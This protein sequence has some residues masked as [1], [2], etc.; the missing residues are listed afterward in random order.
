M[1]KHWSYE[2]KLPCQKEIT[3]LLDFPIHLKIRAITEEMGSYE[4]LGYLLGK[5]ES[6]VFYITDLYIPE[7]EVTPGSVTVKERINLENIIGTVHSHGAGKG[8]K[9][10]ID[11]EHLYAN[12]P[13]FLVTGRDGSYYCEARIKAPCGHWV[14]T[15]AK[16][17]ISYPAEVENAVDE[18][19]TKCKKIGGIQLNLDWKN[20]KGMG[21]E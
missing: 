14:G 6:S 11:K 12:H 2:S 9:S 10:S 19:L 16:V 1:E 20:L 5:M 17:L 8:F 7:Q 3:V 15:K 21:L 4:W 18:A 13:L